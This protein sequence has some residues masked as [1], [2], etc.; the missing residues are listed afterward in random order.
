[1]AVRER[2]LS[3][4]AMAFQAGVASRLGRVDDGSTLSDFDPDEIKRK[5]SVN[6][7]LVPVEWKGTKIN[8]I[9]TPGYADFVGEEKSGLRASDAAVLLVDASAGVQVG[10]ENAWRFTHERELPL[11][12]FVNRIDRENADF[13]RVVDGTGGAVWPPVYPAADA[14]RLAGPF[15][16]HRGSDCYEGAQRR[17][18]RR[19]PGT[20]GY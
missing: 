12:I 16:G 10:T 9:D 20:G 1:M 13:D 8:I 5:I 17:E 14:Y 19:G 11:L 3:T 18:S 4:E 15:H 7:S 2:R 6:L